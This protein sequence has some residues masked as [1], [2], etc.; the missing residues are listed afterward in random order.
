MRARSLTVALGGSLVLSGCVGLGG[1]IAGDFSCPAPDGICAPSSLIDDRA[2]AM[3]SGTADVVPAGPYTPREE[4]IGTVRVAGNGAVARSGQKV[5]KIVFPARVD[6]HGRFHETSAIRAVV[7]NGAWVA[8]SDPSGAVQAQGSPLAGGDALAFQDPR[9]AA[10]GRVDLATAVTLAPAI[11]AAPPPIT[12]EALKAEVEELL[13]R[14][15]T[16]SASAA[17]APALPQAVAGSSA[18]A[19]QPLPAPASLATQAEGPSAPPTTPTA[20]SAAMPAP[21]AT[22]A[23][24]NRPARFSGLVEE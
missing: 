21:A 24:I 9:V 6:R 12:R 14:P 23:A 19:A 3:I 20:V 1:N 22:T 10:P 4:A 15:G 2:L 13:A 17:P 7:D 18:A 11:S 16:R 5:L 8:A